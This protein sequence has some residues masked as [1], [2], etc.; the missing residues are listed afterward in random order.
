MRK[1][2]KCLICTCHVPCCHT[3]LRLLGLGAEGSMHPAG[4]APSLAVLQ[5]T[6]CLSRPASRAS[7]GS[8]SI[9]ATLYAFGKLAF[10]F[11]QHAGN[12]SWVYGGT[13]LDLAACAHVELV[14]SRCEDSSDCTQRCP[15]GHQ[16]LCKAGDRWRGMAMCLYWCRAWASSLRSSGF[17]QCC[18]HQACWW[19][20]RI[21]WA[22]P[23]ERK[24]VVLGL[25]KGTGLMISVLVSGR[26]GLRESKNI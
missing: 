20:C 3:C 24:A 14:V 5:G 22:E 17:S 12:D 16:W 9:S 21:F 15:Q 18:E 6:L 23:R 10:A 26:M 19:T 8:T 11:R 2:Q 7:P 13:G 25:N 1:L 4:S